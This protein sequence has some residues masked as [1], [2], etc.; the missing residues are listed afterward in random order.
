MFV[1]DDSSS[2]QPGIGWN[3]CESSFLPSSQEL[4]AQAW[5]LWES[6]DFWSGSD[7]GLDF[8]SEEYE[9]ACHL[10]DYSFDKEATSPI[11]TS[12]VHRPGV[13]GSRAGGQRC[14]VADVRHLHGQGYH[15]HQCGGGRGLLLLP[16]HL[17]LPRHDPG[18]RLD[19]PGRPLAGGE[20]SPS[21]SCHRPGAVLNP[22]P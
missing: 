14:Q 1:M 13:R 4:C 12:A 10:W 6:Q 3:R 2:T 7:K 9:D 17:D 11:K 16:G 8:E 15:D 22:K 19:H 18:R 21:L 20:P 5:S